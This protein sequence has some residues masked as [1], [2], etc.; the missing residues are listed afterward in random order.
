MSSE[1]KCDNNCIHID[2]IRH[3][4]QWIVNAEEQRASNLVSINVPRGIVVCDRDSQALAL[5]AGVVAAG[6][7]E[8]LNVDVAA[9][10]SES[11]LALA[12]ELAS[13]LRRTRC[14]VDDR[15]YVEF[16]L[17]QNVLMKKLLVPPKLA[18]TK[19]A[20]LLFSG[21]KDSLYSYIALRNNGYEVVPLFTTSNV[22]CKEEER[23]A[24][25]VLLGELGASEGFEVE[26]DLSGLISI[27]RDGGSLDAF[28]LKNAIPYGRDCILVMLAACIASQ[29]G[30]SYVC[31][32][33]EREVLEGT[34]PLGA[35]TIPRHDTQSAEGSKVMAGLIE[36]LY[37]LKLFSPVA[38]LS[39]YGILH[40]LF[41]HHHDL[42][43]NLQFCFWGRWCGQCVK[44]VRYGLI[45]LSLGY[46]GWKF[47]HDI[48]SESNPA[49]NYLL[50]EYYLKYGSFRAGIKY[51]IAA[52]RH[53]GML[54][55]HLWIEKTL[56]EYKLDRTSESELSLQEQQLLQSGT[57]ELAPHNFIV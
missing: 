27:G 5:S 11:C 8:Y 19:R 55:N 3:G 26:M 51:C 7:S 42:C 22:C 47:E 53:R 15:P 24:T 20:L 25:R 56:S 29:I 45:A 44:C 40:R 57:N 49:L 23:H 2:A 4:S 17:T 28:P 46:S 13:L 30:C 6:L 50:S 43:R 10:V 36:N 33:N 16:V 18:A 48:L 41:V 52:L 32:G 37:N 54:T 21:G 38:S 9:H 39:E 1:S 34:I 12:G 14:A 31:V 35:K